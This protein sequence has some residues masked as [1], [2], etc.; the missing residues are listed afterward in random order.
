MVAGHKSGGEWRGMGR[1]RRERDGEGEGGEGEKGKGE[2]E[3]VKGG[4]DSEG[5]KGLRK[6]WGKMYCS[7]KFCMQ[8][9]H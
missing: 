6:L 4:K 3:R 1:E 5:S 7:M 8:L 9:V 2:G